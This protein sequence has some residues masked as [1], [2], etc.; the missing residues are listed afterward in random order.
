MV[1]SQFLNSAILY[2]VIS[3]VL[4][5]SFTNKVGLVLQMTSFIIISGFIN[6]GYTLLNPSALW[7]S[8]KLFCKFRNYADTDTVNKFQ[9]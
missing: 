6:I 7:R 3:R 8:L 9:K 2:F 4:K 1:V 5:D